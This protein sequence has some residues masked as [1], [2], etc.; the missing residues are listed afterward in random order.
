MPKHCPWWPMIL[1]IY[2]AQQPHFQLA[3]CSDDEQLS[4]MEPCHNLGRSCIGKLKSEKLG[5]IDSPIP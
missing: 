5:G 1:F 3:T 2:T 4:G